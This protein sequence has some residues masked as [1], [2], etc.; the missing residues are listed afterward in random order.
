MTE[1]SDRHGKMIDA[2]LRIYRPAMRRYITDTLDDGWYEEWLEQQTERSQWR[3]GVSRQ[4]YEDKKHR[5]QALK[6]GPYWLIEVGDFADI[7]KARESNFPPEIQKLTGAMRK[8]AKGSESRAPRQ[9]GPILEN[10]NTVL[11]EVGGDAAKQIQRLIETGEPDTP[12][13]AEVGSLPDGPNPKDVIRKV[14]EHYLFAMQDYM[15][16]ALHTGHE[17]RTGSFNW[18]QELVLPNWPGHERRTA[19]KRLP[20]TSHKEVIDVGNIEH[21]IRDNPQDFPEELSDG[22]YKDLFVLINQA[23]RDFTGHPARSRRGLKPRAERVAGACVT[24]LTLCD[25]DQVADGIEEIRRI[26]SNQKEPQRVEESVP[27]IADDS[28]PVQGAGPVSEDA[29]GPALLPGDNGPEQGEEAHRREMDTLSYRDP[30]ARSELES[31]ERELEKQPFFGGVLA[32][33]WASEA[34]QSGSSGGGGAFA[35]GGEVAQREPVRGR[36]W[37]PVAGA[38]LAVIFVGLAVAFGFAVSDLWPRGDQIGLETE[39]ATAPS[40]EQARQQESSATEEQSAAEGEGNGGGAPAPPADTDSEPGGRDATEPSSPE[41][42]QTPPDSTVEG[43]TSES[44]DGGQTEAGGGEETEGTDCIT[45]E[46]DECSTEASGEEKTDPLLLAAPVIVNLTCEPDRPDV[47]ETVTCEASLSGDEPDSWSWSGGGEPPI[48]NDDTFTTTFSSGGDRK[49]S[50]TA[51]NA[52]GSD[53]ESFDVEIVSVPDATTDD[54][55]WGDGEM[56]MDDGLG[57]PGL[58]SSEPVVTG[59]PHRAALPPEPIG[60][61]VPPTIPTAGFTAVSAGSTHTCGL[62]ASGT[63]ECWGDYDIGLWIIDT[64]ESATIKTIQAD[65]LTGSFRAVSAGV[66]HTCA[67]RT[68]DE[69]ACWGSNDNRET[70]APPGRFTAVSAGDDHTCAIRINDEIA[71]WGSNDNRETDAPPGRFTA[72][73]AGDDHTCAIRTNGAIACW[74][75]HGLDNF[76]MDSYTALSTSRNTTCAIRTNGA[77]VCW[78][79][80]SDGVHA[81]I[82]AATPAGS[83]RAISLGWDH[84]CAIRTNGAIACWG[85]Y[86]NGETDPPPGSFTAVSAGSHHTCGLR[87]DGV[88]LCWGSNSVGQI[89]APATERA[90]SDDLM[91]D[92]DAMDGGDELGAGEGGDTMMAG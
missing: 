53:S 55:D 11:Q 37:I 5:V 27:E 76:S 58:T 92:G 7:I 75:L 61:T 70:D 24:I 43:E 16:N 82:N 89:D 1:A 87:D 60:G 17:R 71:C 77:I 28:P 31:V 39:S 3:K 44:D 52:A 86:N 15:G 84:T 48:G 25:S 65:A 50:L 74:G 54:E 21:T 45:N 88:I 49:I 8:I 33:L 79:F 9:V 38:I 12:W 2:A 42:A 18:F 47:G 59:E 73:S 81:V 14:I 22:T 63:I 32:R 56:E 72:V 40:G 80:S 57:D 4:Y 67:I 85:S 34:A 46:N 62:R 35:A 36:R 83:F 51:G 90:T 69:I 10:C 68:N 23:R 26:F 19:E 29:L 78:G 91:E 6:L 20:D 13:E 41:S 30:E 64:G 66:A